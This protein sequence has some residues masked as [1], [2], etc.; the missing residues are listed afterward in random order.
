MSKISYGRQNDKIEC[1]RYKNWSKTYP[2][3]THTSHLT[4]WYIGEGKLCL[5]LNGKQK[6]YSKGERFRIPPDVLHEIMVVLC[7]QIKEQSAESAAAFES[8]ASYKENWIQLLFLNILNMT[9][10]CQELDDRIKIMENQVLLDNITKIHTTQMG[11][12]R[13]RKNLH[14]S[15]ETDTV[16]YCRQKIL[17]PKCNIYKQGKNWYCEIGGMKITVNSYSYTIITAHT[18]K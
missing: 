5:T 3:H 2:P 4:V 14:L 11:A 15:A 17:D 6:N 18:I 7:I 1:I 12:E 13:I 9:Y 16:E 10:R 8:P